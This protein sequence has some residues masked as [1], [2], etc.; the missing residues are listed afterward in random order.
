VGTLVAINTLS[1]VGHDVRI[2]DYTT[3]SAHV[4]LTG[5]VQTGQA[6][7]FGSGARVLPKVRIGDGARIGAG[8]TV[9]RNVPAGA[10]MYVPPARRL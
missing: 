1:S 3:L 2:G 7:F 9:V 4:D 10:V 5:H 8:A 6:C